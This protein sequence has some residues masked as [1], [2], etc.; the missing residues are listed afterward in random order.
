VC[1]KKSYKPTGLKSNR[2]GKESEKLQHATWKSHFPIQ[3]FGLLN[4][5]FH[6][7]SFS[8]QVGHH[9][10][11]YSLPVD[12]AREQDSYSPSQEAAF[13]C[14]SLTKHGHCEQDSGAGRQIQHQHC[15]FRTP[16][17][18]LQGTVENDQVHHCTWWVQGP[19]GH[20]QSTNFQHW[21]LF[22]QHKVGQRQLFPKFGLFFLL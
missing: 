2:K 17:E 15:A 14:R 18:V 10:L 5:P 3:V 7:V 9:Q 8:N 4:T 12:E 20:P 21:L 22:V 13:G 19:L 1:V 11:W 6:V 16:N